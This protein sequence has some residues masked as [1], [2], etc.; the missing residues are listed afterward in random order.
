[1]LY[2]LEK[3][4]KFVSHTLMLLYF[5][6]KILQLCDI[7]PFGF[8]NI[9]AVNFTALGTLPYQRCPSFWWNFLLMMVVYMPPKRVG[10]KGIL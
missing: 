7:L 4:R 9:H 1:M 5:L 8:K 10:V 2:L 6:E 3:I